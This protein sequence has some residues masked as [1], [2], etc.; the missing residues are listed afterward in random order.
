MKFPSILLLLLPNKE[1]KLSE[2]EEK[3]N[4][5]DKEKIE[6]FRFPKNRQNLYKMIDSLESEHLI[7]CSYEN[8]LGREKLIKI[9]PKGENILKL[10]N[11][12][13]EKRRFGEILPD[14]KEKIKQIKEKIQSLYAEILKLLKES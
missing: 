5:M 14:K 12:L 2:L 4:E 7:T 9:S 11:E 8:K 13:L 3:I 1:I 6:I 10:L